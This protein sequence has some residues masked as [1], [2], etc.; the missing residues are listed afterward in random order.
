M[1]LTSKIIDGVDYNFFVKLNITN[2]TFGGPDRAADVSMSIRG[3][4]KT[5]F[6]TVEG[7]NPIEYSFNGNTLHGDLTPATSTAHLEFEKRPLNKIWFRAPT[8]ASIVR[9]EAWAMT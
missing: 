5:L 9:V 3:A 1:T 6:L 4:V 2:T 7:G 8:G